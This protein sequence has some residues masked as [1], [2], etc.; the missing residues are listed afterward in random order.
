MG[1]VINTV[2]TALSPPLMVVGEKLLLSVALVPM[3]RVR[4]ALADAALVTPRAVVTLPA[5]MVL[6]TVPVPAGAWMSTAKVQVLAPAGMP[7]PASEK[8][9]LLAVA[10]VEPPQLVTAFGGFATVWPAGSASVTF[11]LVKGSAPAAWAK[12][13]VRRLTC[14]GPMMVGK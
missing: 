9:A 8:L 6:A 13:R 2:S 12:V 14:E 5:A 1:L 3:V 10:T 7:A 4:L 11:M